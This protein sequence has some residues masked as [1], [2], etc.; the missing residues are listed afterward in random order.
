MA[1]TVQ[2]YALTATAPWLAPDGTTQPIGTV[3]ALALWDGVTP[4][5]PPAGFQMVLYTNQHVYV[6]VQPAPTIIDVFD[7]FARFTTA[8]FNALCANATANAIIHRMTAYGQKGGG[9]NVTDP[10]I[11]GY[12]GQAV[13]ANLLTSARSTQILNLSVSSP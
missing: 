7:F 1:G 9:I 4:Y 8:E 2:T 3:S 12:M 6:P 10:I 11:T 5:T 13:A